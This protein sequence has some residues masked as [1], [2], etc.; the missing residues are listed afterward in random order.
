MIKVNLK[1]ENTNYVE[2]KVSGHAMYDVL[3]KDIVCSA[4]SSIVTTTV[5]GILLL[6]E[7]SIC[8]K[9]SEGNIIINNISDDNITQKLLENMVNL[10]KELVKQYPTNIIVK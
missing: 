10:L 6:N 2:I 5:N 1:L 8:Y 7:G 9:V 3:G 4:V